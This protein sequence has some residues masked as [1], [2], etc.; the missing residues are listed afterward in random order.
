MSVLFYGLGLILI[1][2][3]IHLFLWKIHLP[4]N[5]TKALLQIF[6]GTLTGGIF[7]LWRF[8]NYIAFFNIPTPV[9]LYEYMQLS[10]F[11]VSLVLAYVITY[12]ALEADSPSFVMVLSIAE[13]G[14]KGL[15]KNTF[16]QRINNDVLVIPRVR[17]L[18]AGGM[19]YLDGEVYK[20]KP[21]G[22]FI[23]RIFITYRSF[24][25]RAQKGG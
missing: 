6:F 9:S 11:F 7:I 13:A 15:D 24:L 12:S 17:D 2:F 8:S 1:A 4:Q 10:F 21:K 20:L 18:L 19:V 3:V 22:I 14:S 16:E 23:A 5:H 25:K